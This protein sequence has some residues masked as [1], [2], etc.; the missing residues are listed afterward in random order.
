MNDPATIVENRDALQR[1]QRGGFDHLLQALQSPEVYT[2]GDRL[3]V[4]KLARVMNLA[5][6]RVRQM[7]A[8]ARTML[9]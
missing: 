4:K 2:S 1:L 8:D 3:V 7:L 6:E 9:E 5:P